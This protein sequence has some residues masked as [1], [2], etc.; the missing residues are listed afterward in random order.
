MF[1]SQFLMATQI[2]IHILLPQHQ[3]TTLLAFVGVHHSNEVRP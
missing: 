2:I 3:C 1:P